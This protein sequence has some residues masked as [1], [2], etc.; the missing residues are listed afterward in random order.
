ML[1]ENTVAGQLV[2]MLFVDF[3]ERMK[4]GT[5]LGDD[6]ISVLLLDALVATICLSR[7]ALFEA[8]L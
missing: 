8:D 3:G 6:A 5:F 7:G 1:V 4:L 2:V